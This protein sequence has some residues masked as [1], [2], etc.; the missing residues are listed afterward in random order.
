M[1]LCAPYTSSCAAGVGDPLTR[2]ERHSRLTPDTPRAH[3]AS[4]ETSARGAGRHCDEVCSR[5]R[6]TIASSWTPALPA[7]A[8]I[9]SLA[10]S[11]W[12]PGSPAPLHL[13]SQQQSHG[14]GEVDRALTTQRP[15][16]LS[17]SPLRLSL[18][19][20]APQ[21]VALCASAC[22]SLRLS[23]SPSAPQPVALEETRRQQLS[24]AQRWRSSRRPARRRQ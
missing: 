20:S 18:S 22:R 7:L 3:C 1:S 16:R 9:S 24:S 12:R 23:W 11:I 13:S 10:S 15:L 6:W 8:R 14:A 4:T 17:R 5:A 19:L 21:P 2:R